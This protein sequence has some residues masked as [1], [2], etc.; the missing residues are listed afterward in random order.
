MFNN[1]ERQCIKE[2]IKVLD[3]YGFSIDSA[4]PKKILNDDELYFKK[5]KRLRGILKNFNADNKQLSVQKLKGILAVLKIK[6]EKD[7]VLCCRKALEIIEEPSGE[8]IG[9]VKNK[10]KRIIDFL[11]NP[12]G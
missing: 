8:S 9:D 6:T 1:K 2:I 11:T 7:P 10:I 4:L 3:K 5:L 12:N